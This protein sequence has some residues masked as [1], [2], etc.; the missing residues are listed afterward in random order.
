M[1]GQGVWA[2]GHL[3]VGARST[4][5][6]PNSPSRGPGKP[7]PSASPHPLPLKL[8]PLTPPPPPGA[9]S[10]LLCQLCV[11]PAAPPAKGALSAAL[12]QRLEAERDPHGKLRGPALGTRAC[13][14]HHV[15]TWRRKARCPGA[16]AG[17]GRHL[18][19]RRGR[20]GAAR[21]S[22]GSLEPST[23]S[24]PRR[25]PVCLLQD[26]AGVFVLGSREPSFSGGETGLQA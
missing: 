9:A 14:S 24:W 22:L 21:C 12:L 16:G 10:T 19:A 18:V 13:S 26:Q 15:L 25:A 6:H 4:S 7:G 5:S 11:R 23:R 17:G 2:T 20:Q 8:A 3:S 1:E